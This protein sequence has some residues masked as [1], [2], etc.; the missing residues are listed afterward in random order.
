MYHLHL[1]SKPELN[2]LQ[3]QAEAL[4]RLHG[5]KHP[6]AATRLS[7]VLKGHSQ[8]QNLVGFKTNLTLNTAKLVVAKEYGF[9]DWK[10][11]ENKL[12]Q[13]PVSMTKVHRLAGLKASDYQ[14]LADHLEEG[15][16][17]GNPEVR[18]RLQAHGLDA[19]SGGSV[20]ISTS[21]CRD[22]VALE[23]GFPNWNSLTSHLKYLEEHSKKPA[24][25]VYLEA[26]KAVEKGDLKNLKTLLANYPAVVNA[27]DE[28]LLDRLAQ[29]ETESLPEEVQ[30]EMFQLL[31]NAGSLLDRSLVV[32]ACF[33]RVSVIERLIAA[34]AAPDTCVEWGLTPLES[35]ILHGSAVAA[36]AL[37][38]HG[39]YRNT[40]WVAAGA[41]RLEIVENWFDPSG[42]LRPG[43]HKHRPNFADIGLPVGLPPVPGQQAVMEEAMVQACGN[44]RTQVA[45]FFLDRGVSIN[46][47]PYKKITGLHLAAW[48]GFTETVAML[49]KRG[50]ELAGVDELNLSTPL[51]YAVYNG[52]KE[53]EAFLRKHTFQ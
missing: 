24:D 22:I 11:L 41:G 18:R 42:K 37:A 12:K 20:A 46:A 47:A 13:L 3:K 17:K 28:R 49:V 25:K 50:A 8:L 21:L 27:G 52:H 48:R 15:L 38:K 30:S 2:V 23:H 9:S 7:S 16:R 35:A 14:Q 26:I 51:G 34:G 33:G 40:L 4:L 29:P 31:V 39:L 36:D 1:P 19:S 32:A 53:T 45:A 44:G 10:A 5:A 43:A 6:A